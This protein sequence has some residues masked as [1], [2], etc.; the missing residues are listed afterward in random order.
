MATTKIIKNK[1]TI[2]P[3]EG[4][5]V[6]FKQSWTETAKESFCAFANSAGGHVYFGI[7]DD[8]KVAGVEKPDEI[9]RSAES[10]FRFAM[11]P[12]G[13]DICRTEI[14][15]IDDKPVVVVHVLEGEKAP[16]Y[17]TIKTSK[18]KKKICY[19]RHGS[20][21][22]EATDEEERR[23]YQ[24]S[25]P[26]AYE[27]RPARKQ[28][29]TFKTLE[30]YFKAANI[31]FSRRYY[32]P[33]GMVTDKGFYTNL[34]WWVS[35]QNESETRLGFFTGPDRGA[36]A[37]GL[38]TFKGC[39]IEQYDSVRRMLNNRFGF[40]HE[41]PPFDLRRDGS[42]NEVREYPE[43]AV[44]EAL[45]NMFAHRDYSVEN[46]QACV[47]C[48]TDHLE[49]MSYGGL[50]PETDMETLKAGVSLPRNRN[51]AEM[52]MRLSA[53]EKYG[54][55]IPLMY[56]SYK[57]FGMEPTFIVAPRLLRILLP[58]VTL[59]YG[60]LTERE[61]TVVEFLRSKGPVARSEVQDYLGKSYSTAINVLRSLETKRVVV[62]EGA[63]RDTR[64]RL[65]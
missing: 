12:Q 55:G 50:P 60:E 34:A 8:G 29:L 47:S 5:M 57:P 39:L 53:M 26:V 7:T 37:D 23:L 56:S 11:S 10:V 52:L 16:Y 14:L 22:Y 28:E 40:A 36:P 48:F 17:V 65:A 9:A 51:L 41:I 6:E 61:K 15:K 33:L 2:P 19:L 44:R 42:R 3:A 18:G 59:H 21:N 24:K 25:N 45:V 4:F 32:Q 46:A 54:L 38:Y 62:K 64:Y 49:M 35:D 27:L 31:P 30:K 63:G 13:D 1:E 58:K 20:S 43:T